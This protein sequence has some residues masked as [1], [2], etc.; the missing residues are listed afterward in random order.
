M[1]NDCQGSI[2][3]CAIDVFINNDIISIISCYRPPAAPT[4]GV[5]SWVNFL[6]QFNSACLFC[7]D[8]NV[9]NGC[10]PIEISLDTFV[11]TATQIAFQLP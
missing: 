8:F 4:I 2:E 1:V 10:F 6:S 11:H 5:A 7:G 3:A 9:H